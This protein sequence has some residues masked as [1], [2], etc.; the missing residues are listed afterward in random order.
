[1]ED[2][3]RDGNKSTLNALIA[4]LIA[5]NIVSIIVTSVNAS[6]LCL[7]WILKI[8]APFAIVSLAFVTK[9]C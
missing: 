9:T 3:A 5:N 4:I 2:C 8:H 1:M 7:N 6:L